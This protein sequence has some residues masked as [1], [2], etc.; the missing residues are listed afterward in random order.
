MRIR[1]TLAHLALAFALTG[2]PSSHSG[3]PDDCPEVAGSCMDACCT[4]S[5]DPIRYEG[6]TP[7]CPEGTS[8]VDRCAPAPG[9]GADAGTCPMPGMLPPTCA[10]GPC[11]TTTH[12][13]AVWDCATLAWSC[14]DGGDPSC[15]PDPG[16]RCAAPYL[17]CDEPT[18]CVLAS[19]QCCGPCERTLANSDSVNRDRVDEYFDRDAECGDVLCE[20]C[21][22]PSSDPLRP[23]VF[24]TCG[25]D[26]RG[27]LCT[28]FDLRIEAFT[29]CS[30]DTDC[31]VRTP[32]CCE[33][34]GDTSDLA[35]I[36]I[37]VDA[38]GA[39]AQRVCPSD[40]ACPEC[41]PDY[42][43]DVSAYCAEDG[44]CAVAIA[45]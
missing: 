44:H 22:P 11:C 43:S 1:L 37:R 14:P 27:D 4:G 2:C 20:P 19:D 13:M 30:T 6:C 28:A 38:E 5:R 45:P 35:L 26:G 32:D 34:G 25:A 12:G 3:P 23:R 7:V 40:T 18:D 41:L 16:A 9:C 10:S 33:C 8:F 36:A 39:F 15:D 42:P 24:P 17:G 31:L 21:P 29:E